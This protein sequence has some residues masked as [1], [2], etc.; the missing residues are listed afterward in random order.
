M[1]KFFII[2][3]MLSQF[4]IGDEVSAD[5]RID[6]SG[7]LHVYGNF[8]RDQITSSMTDGMT[9]RY[10]DV[11]GVLIIESSMTAT[12]VTA[13]DQCLFSGLPIREVIVEQ[14]VQELG[15]FW[16][17]G[18]SGLTRVS[19]SDSVQTIG[20]SCFEKCI[21]LRKLSFCED[22]H[23]TTISERAFYGCLS[24]FFLG[25]PSRVQTIGD[26]CFKGCVDLREV[27]FISP[28]LLTTIPKEA[29]SGCR[30]LIS[31]TIPS[32]VENI[33]DLCFEGCLWLRFVKVSPYIKNIGDSCFKGCE[34]ID[35]DKI[36]IKLPKS[37]PTEEH[38]QCLLL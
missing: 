14:G 28:S 37:L 13:T 33:G 20:E 34:G 16:F 26:S 27:S 12:E 29:F 38:K 18:C 9:D 17:F 24:L 23:L 4:I 30:S 7:R 8:C 21:F 35:L 5:V 2:A 36:L 19:I 11:N 31:I 15:K 6:E 32:S 3:T 25:I 1:K 22:S 10:G